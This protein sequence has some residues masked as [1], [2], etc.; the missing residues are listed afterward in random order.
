MY[1]KRFYTY[2][3]F[4]KRYSSNTLEA[5]T[6]DLTQFSDF[7]LQEYQENDPDLIH[8]HHRQ[9]RA[10]VISMMDHGIASKSVNRKISS[11]KTYFRFLLKQ[12]AITK[13]PTSKVISPKLPKQLP[14]FVEENSMESIFKLIEEVYPENTPEELFEKKRNQLVIEI[15]YGTGMRR[16]ELL[17][18]TDRSFDKSLRMVKVLGKGNKER[19]IPVH[20]QLMKL[21]F[22]YIELRNKLVGENEFLLVTFKGKKA[23]PNMIYHIVNT[24]LAHVSTLTRKSPHVLRHTIATHLSNSG[25]ELNAIK[26]LLGHASLAST[27]VYTHNTIEKLKEVHKQAHPKG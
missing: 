10:W 24:L 26:E 1:L 13:N 23:Y 21:V 9:I 7:I 20:D 18:L 25:A 16:A 8:V 5:Y 6:L 12:G 22:D 14:V 2:L 15:L 19:I 27:Q 4:E 11:L 3:Q 17:S